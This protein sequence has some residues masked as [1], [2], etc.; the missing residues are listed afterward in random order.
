MKQKVDNMN[1]PFFEPLINHQ[2]IGVFREHSNQ[3]RQGHQISLTNNK[4]VDKNINTL[5]IKYKFKLRLKSPIPN[6]TILKN[7]K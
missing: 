4:I 5:N 7:P 6:P 2:F 3:L 1:A